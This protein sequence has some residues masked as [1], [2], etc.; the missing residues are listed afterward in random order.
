MGVPVCLPLTNSSPPFSVLSLVSIFLV[1]TLS[2]VLLQ[3]T[4]PDTHQ[5][6]HQSLTSDQSLIGHHV[7]DD[8]WWFPGDARC[9]DTEDRSCVRRQ[10]GRGEQTGGSRGWGG[11]RPVWGGIPGFEEEN[12][13]RYPPTNGGRKIVLHIMA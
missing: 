10:D 7:Q 12:I 11:H 5:S 9:E 13:S 4:V 6:S 1:I 8:H 3:A 2:P